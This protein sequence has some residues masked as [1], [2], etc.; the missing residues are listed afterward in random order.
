MKIRSII[1]I[2]ACMALCLIPSVGML[3]FPTTETT[4]N[5]AMAAPPA[6]LTEEGSLNR[7]FFKDFETWFNQRVALRNQL[8][9][10]D[11]MVQ[12]KV[13]QE[14][15]VSGVIAGTDGWL[16][17]SSTLED[18]QGQN[19]LSERDLYNLASNFSLVEEYL[20]DREIGFVLTIP[21][22]K[23][24]LYPENMPYYKSLVV[25]ENHNA[26]LLAPYLEKQEVSYVDL[27]ALFEKQE[28]TLYLKRDSHWN[29]KGAYMAYSAMLD[30]LSLDYR[31]YA[32]PT[33][34]KTANGDL[35]KMLYSFYGPLEENY[36]YDLPGS[37]AYKTGDSVDDGWIITG[38]KKGEG[39][40][41]MF[42]DSF[43][44]TLIPFLSEEFETAYYSKEMPNGL[45]P[46][47]ESYEPDCVIIEKV[48]R[49]MADYLRNPPILTP[50]EV[51]LP[52]DLTLA[53]TAATAT[54]ENFENDARYYKLSGTVTDS[55]LKTDSRILIS[56]DGR[57]CRVYQWGEGDFFAYL[58]K[59]L[60][61]ESSARVEV[62]IL[63]ADSAIQVLS[64]TLE[65]PAE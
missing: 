44:D 31:K 42:R 49:N 28:E 1:F 18:Y 21:P 38:N 63:E 22:N 53:K 41:L 56:V 51:E 6:I 7:D 17:Y 48:E 3:F 58:K 13:F 55:R 65:C 39:T 43:A 27:F 32:A 11:A 59:D 8:I 30:Q 34:E 19:L 5:K 46:Y 24:T 36:T 12:T 23:N 37:Y 40:L 33:L 35:N 64:T 29:N 25:N 45:E 47:V 20:K 57:A 26:K 10:T 54:L 16:Y 2:A 4:E 61:A 15:N 60:F 9:Y 14:S 52:A 62:Y 50:A